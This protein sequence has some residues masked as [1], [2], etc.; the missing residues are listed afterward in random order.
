MVS[1]ATAP[2][3]N[4]A[5]S[6]V[7]GPIPVRRRSRLVSVGAELATARQVLYQHE[8]LWRGFHFQRTL[9]DDVVRAVRPGSGIW[10]SAQLKQGVSAG[11]WLGGH[12]PMENRR[13]RR[14]NCFSRN[15]APF[16]SQLE[17]YPAVAYHSDGTTGRVPGVGSIFFGWGWPTSRAGR[18][19]P[20]MEGPD[21][22]RRCGGPE[23]ENPWY[24]HAS[25]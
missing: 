19:P 13:F 16:R 4:K 25:A 14:E 6:Q 5:R 17:Q 20:A 23:A 15:T 8:L 21:D 10:R 3:R 11:C 2:S 12:A 1:R 7:A 22:E 18:R 24:L 9:G